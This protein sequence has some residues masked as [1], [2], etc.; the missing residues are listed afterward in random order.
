MLHL[1]RSARYLK[2]RRLPWLTFGTRPKTDRRWHFDILIAEDAFRIQETVSH[3]AVRS[4][5]LSQ[6]AD[7]VVGNPPWGA[8]QTNVPEELRSDGGLEWCESRSLAVGDKERSQTFIHRTLDLL[9]PGGRA[10]LLVSTGVF[11]K[12]HKNTRRFRKQ[13]LENTSL[14]KVVNFAAVR[15][16][17]FQTGAEEGESRKAR[18]HRSI[19]LPWYSTTILLQRTI[20]LLIGQ[21]RKQH[22]SKRVQAVVL[23]RAD[24]RIAEQLKYLHDETLWKIYWWGGHRDEALICRLRLEHSFKQEVDPSGTRMRVG[25]QEASRKDPAGWLKKF[26]EFPTRTFERYGAPSQT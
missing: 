6:C 12:R 2:N 5:F 14:V 24:M 9:R 11:F 18:G 25:F 1:S 3:E 21:Q 16:S 13:W 4:R 22:S 7:V 8:P 23:N 19:L 15:N 17:F 26:K 20:I 10:G